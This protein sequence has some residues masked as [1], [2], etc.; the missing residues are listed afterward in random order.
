MG[1]ILDTS[2]SPSSIPHT[3]IR[4][5]TYYF[6][7]RVPK[8][9]QQLYGQSIRARLSECEE[10]ARTLATHLSHLLKQSW[11]SNTKVKVCIDEALSS[12]RPAKVTFA[13]IAEEYIETRQLGRRS[14][15]VPIAALLTVAGDRA[16]ASYKR[17][18]CQHR[19]ITQP[20]TCYP[21]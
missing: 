11:Q 7:M 19:P 21:L 13:A 10:E 8:Q 1:Y 20:D 5:R 12:V 9:H 16:V 15:Q 2:Q 3:V 4:G 18:H 14:C 6:Q 17:E